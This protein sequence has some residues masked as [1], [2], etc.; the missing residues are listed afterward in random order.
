MNSMLKEVRV[1]DA[2][3]TVLTHDLTQ[4]LPGEFK[5]RRFKKGHVIREQDIPDLLSIG[6][7]HL[8]VLHLKQGYVHEEEAALRLAQALAGE[9]TMLTEPYEGKVTIKS[10]IHGI[11]K[12]EKTIVDEINQLKDIS[13]AT[14][15]KDVVVKPGDSIVGARVTPLIMDESMIEQVESYLLDSEKKVFVKPFLPLKVG[16]VTTGS[17]IFKG[18][19]KDKFGPVVMGKVQHLGGM[20]LGQK[21][22]NDDKEMIVQHIEAFIHEG[23]DIVFV[24]GGMS[25]DPDDRSPGAIYDVATE[26]IRYG[27]PML[28]GSMLMM[29]YKGEIPIVGLPG[30]VMHDPFT[31]FD[32]LLPKIMAGEKINETDITTLGYGGLL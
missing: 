15:R 32:V 11:L 27:T 18:R 28:P 12:I 22:S 8:Y 31:S 16:I 4:I 14:K 21:L 7:E 9:N 17:E 3:G 30:C 24:T 6:K 25:V 20:I 29:A 26:V 13:V 1:E 5:G 19:I 23:A 10:T 2:V